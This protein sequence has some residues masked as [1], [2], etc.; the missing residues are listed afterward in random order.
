MDSE[1]QALTALQ[2]GAHEVKDPVGAE[3]I[4]KVDLQQFRTFLKRKHEESGTTVSYDALTAAQTTQS[5][6]L[7][8]NQALDAEFRARRMALK[9]LE[10]ASFSLWT[11]ELQRAWQGNLFAP[12]DDPQ[13][14]EQ[15]DMG[16]LKQSYLSKDRLMAEFPKTQLDMYTYGEGTES[17]HEASLARLLPQDSLERK[18]AVLDSILQYH[19]G[20][21]RAWG[22][23]WVLRQGPMDA[24]QWA[25]PAPV[26]EVLALELRTNPLGTPSYVPQTY[27]EQEVFKQIADGIRPA[28]DKIVGFFWA[29]GTAVASGTEQTHLVRR[30]QSWDLPSMI[31]MLGQS[32]TFKEIYQVWCL[33]PLIV[34]PQRRGKGEGIRQKKITEL[35]THRQKTAEIK[36]FLSSVGL[37]FPQSQ[38]EIRFALQ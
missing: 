16:S 23:D 8:A 19:I 26:A 18:Y 22:G 13:G 4:R 11:P 5:K 35:A 34:K 21:V 31:T 7:E 29:P 17:S 6:A 32:W 25:K 33:M 12:S 38:Q 20:E 15:F 30:V 10:V 28:M 14:P 36:S 2:Q 37:R 1:L 27:T 24:P 3:V 9:P